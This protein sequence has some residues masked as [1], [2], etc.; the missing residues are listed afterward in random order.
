L[1]GRYLETAELAQRYTAYLDTLNGLRRLDEIR[2]FRSL[3]YAA[4][5]Q[6]ILA[7]ADRPAP[8]QLENRP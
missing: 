1:R 4:K 6:R 8:L 5:K 3:D 7:L 2:S